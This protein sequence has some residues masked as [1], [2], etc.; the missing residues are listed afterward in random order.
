MRLDVYLYTFT[1]V[2]TQTTPGPIEHGAKDTPRDF[3]A[4]HI[5][6]SSRHCKH[7]SFTELLRV[8]TRV[9]A[10]ICDSTGKIRNPLFASHSFPSHSEAP[11]LQSFLTCVFKHNGP[12]GGVVATPRYIFITLSSRRHCCSDAPASSLTW[13]TQGCRL[14]FALET[15]ALAVKHSAVVLPALVVAPTARRV[16]SGTGEG[17]GVGQ[18]K[19]HRQPRGSSLPDGCCERLRNSRA[20]GSR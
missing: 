10:Y 20:P 7:D 14:M 18:P 16:N 12:S 2:L 9:P 11:A 15:A 1:P 13:E 5:A 17:G 19:S 6:C 3:A 4:K 8:S